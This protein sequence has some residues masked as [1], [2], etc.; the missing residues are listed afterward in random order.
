MQ[1]NKTT[2]PMKN[3]MLEYSKLILAKVSFHP[4]LLKKEYRKAI[5]HLTKEE[6]KELSE[7]LKANFLHPNQTPQ[8]GFAE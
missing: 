2:K 4:E 7:W 1:E 6:A 5:T 3:S 8:F